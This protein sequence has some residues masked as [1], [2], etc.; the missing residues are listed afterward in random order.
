[1]RGALVV[2]AKVPRA[3]FVK[4][5]MVP[6]LTPDLAAEFYACL[7][8]DVLEVSGAAAR[9]LDLRPVL[10][11]HPP[12]EASALR[13]LAPGFELLPQRGANLSE[14]MEAA[15]SDTA[16]AGAGPIL[17]RGSDS[18]ALDASILAEALEALESHDLVLC[19][20][21]DGGYNLVG[22]KGPAP[23][24]FDHP[25]STDSVLED[26]LAR[27][28]SLGLR[29]RVLAPGFDLDTVEDFRFLAEARDR[30]GHLCPRTL[31]FAD[32]HRLW[33]YLTEN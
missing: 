11:V 2:F 24:L 6:P 22:S 9:E 17:M 14:R 29:A 18:P 15:L 7:L 20:D 33:S 26:T 30:W 3:G 1:M 32:E 12:G 21:R 25:M 4:T 23:G 13:G 8:Q 27:G 16:A 5:R 28:R 10:A 19:P 31:G